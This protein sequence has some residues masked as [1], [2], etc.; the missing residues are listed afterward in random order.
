MK[1]VSVWMYSVL[2]AILI[3]GAHPAH[4]FNPLT[5]IQQNLQ[6]KFGSVAQAGEGYNFTSKQWDT[7]ALAEI[8]EYRFISF[9]YGGTQLD[10]NS[11]AATD[12]FKVGFLSNFFFQLFKNQPPPS[13]MWM[14]N[15]NVGPSFA[16][17]VFSQSTN[18]KGTFLMDIN[19]KF[20]N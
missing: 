14:E 4:A 10:Q 6:W 5:D 8:A 9:S 13:M 11:N 7:S 1:I 18:H 20:G 2:A 12:T 15:L 19:F 3:G 16:I 17:P